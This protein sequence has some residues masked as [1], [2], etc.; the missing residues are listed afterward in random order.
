MYSYYRVRTD[1]DLELTYKLNTRG[2]TQ[3]WAELIAG[4]STVD[5]R[6]DYRPVRGVQFGAQASILDELDSLIVI[7]NSWMPT[8]I[9]GGV[10]RSDIVGSLNRLHVHFPTLEA[11]E[12]DPVRLSQLTRYND[13][14]HD[15]QNAAALNPYI[16][17]CYSSH[18]TQPL[19]AED[20]TLFNTSW[21][22]GSLLLHYPHVGRHPLEL[23]LSKD[24]D[25]PPDQIIP[26]TSLSANHSLRFS[27]CRVHRG[28]FAG[29]YHRSGLAWPYALDDSR[30]A[31]GYIPM[32]QLEMGA[33]TRVKILAKLMRAREIVDFAV[34]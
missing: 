31:L 30:L 7:L 18:Q 29:F 21:E 17:L 2:V 33:L 19:Q 12:T 8:P 11:S 22:F 25:C 1:N 15:A 3:R 27:S 23:M 10:D 5:L 4:L 14:I 16:L 9:A 26:Q 34:Y 20:Y 32:G 24:H 13:L 6:S 28:D